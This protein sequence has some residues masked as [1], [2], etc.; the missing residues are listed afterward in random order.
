M[1]AL[2]VDAFLVVGVTILIVI[3]LIINLYIIAYFQHPDDKNQSYYAKTLI[4]FGFMLT[5]LSVLLIPVDVANNEGSP[6]CD[7]PD[8]PTT[9]Y[10]GGLK[11]FIFYE[12]LFCM[13]C[14]VV[15]GLVP[16]ATF[17]YE[18]TG[19]N[20]PDQC[21][22]LTALI[23]ESVVTFAFLIILLPLFF[24]SASTSIPVTEYTYELSAVTVNEYTNPE[25][26]SPYDFISLQLPQSDFDISNSKSIDA[27]TYSVSFPVY[28]IGLAGWIGWFLFSV[29]LGVGLTS[30]P[31]DFILSFI[32][33][34]R[35]LPPDEFAQ[36]EIEIQERTNDILEIAK[37]LRKDHKGFIEGFAS[38]G[39]KRKRMVTDRL[40]VNKLAQMVYILEKDV[41][42]LK[43]CKNFMNEYNP[44]IPYFKLVAGCVFGSVSLLWLLQIILYMLTDPPISKFL[45]EYLI[46]FDTFF[47]MFGNISYAFLS[48]YLLFCTISGCFKI[49]LRFLCI[50]IHPMEANATY[51]N[52]FLF[53]LAI[54]MIC[55][56]PIVHFC[57]IALGGYTRNTD[58]YLMF[59]VQIGHLHFYSTF[60]EK[61]VFPY[62]VLIS[63]GCMMLYLL[64]KP[65]D[66][67]TTPEDFKQM[68]YKRG[69][70]DYTAVSL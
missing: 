30:M 55:T 25:G 58:S 12:V 20:G 39:E 67:A 41:E 27:I 59:K 24:T 13:I 10:C 22:F 57:T 8:Q 28:L 64:W 4:I 44:L 46:S 48:L 18:G 19:A 54:M 50:K 66:M 60:Y 29:F 23:Y 36:K 47:P 14:F 56:I 11:T 3:L 15:I 38:K 35:Q 9:L 7:L 69:A 31:F 70:N 33:R 40:E 42:A 16:F 68:L 63:A 5:S 65:R 45:N 53:N 21:R 34:P 17:Y 51:T 49:G 43:A 62:V 2:A 1:T 32:Y 52:S 26:R 61:N 6:G 37:L